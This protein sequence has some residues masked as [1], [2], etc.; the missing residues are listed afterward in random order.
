M[1]TTLKLFKLELAPVYRY[2]APFSFTPAFAFLSPFLSI[3]RSLPTFPYP[4]ALLRLF[5]V[6]S[7]LP[8]SL[9]LSLS[10]SRTP[11]YT[12][13]AGSPP[14]FSTDRTSSCTLPSVLVAAPFAPYFGGLRPVQPQCC[15]FSE[16]ATLD[17]GSIFLL[18][19]LGTTLLFFPTACTHT[20]TCTDT[21]F[22]FEGLTFGFT[23]YI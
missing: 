22:R 1:F 11:A 17:S 3:S 19:S 7:S 6:A 8:L 12:L 2:L 20:H 13:G 18:I 16:S 23:H 9:L 10:F 14:L 4:R 15:Q 5:P 21:C